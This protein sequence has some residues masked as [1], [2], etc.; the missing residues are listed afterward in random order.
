LLHDTLAHNLLRPNNISFEGEM[1]GFIDE[2][3]LRDQMDLPG[4]K[5]D[6]GFTI[7]PKNLDEFLDFVNIK[8]RRVYANESGQSINSLPL[9]DRQ[10]VSKWYQEASQRLNE[11]CSINPNFTDMFFNLSQKGKELDMLKL[12]EVKVPLEWFAELYQ[13]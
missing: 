5:L 6:D 9:I 2:G 8:G 7:I 13:K 3:T 1:R 11:V 12:L 4:D 10:T